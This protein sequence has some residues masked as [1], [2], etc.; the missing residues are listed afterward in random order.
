MNDYL[1]VLTG[2]HSVQ[3]DK[4]ASEKENVYQVLRKILNVIWA[5]KGEKVEIDV[6]LPRRQFYQ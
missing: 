3:P 6:S 2:K 5:L 1:T 4:T